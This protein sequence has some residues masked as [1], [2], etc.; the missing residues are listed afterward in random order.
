M[1][2]T[3]LNLSALRPR[4]LSKA[5]QAITPS[6]LFSKEPLFV[7]NRREMLG[8]MGFLG[9]IPMVNSVGTT[10]L[11]SVT[12][13]T[14]K[15]RIVFRMRGKEKWII[16]T[17]LFGGKPRLSLDRSAE[18]LCI[19]LKNATYPGTGVSAD[20]TCTLSPTIKGWRMLLQMPNGFENEGGFESWLLRMRRVLSTAALN[21]T[22][23]TP[24]GD[25]LVQLKGKAAAT[26]WPDWT[27]SL[28]RPR[29]ATIN[30]PEGTLLA[31]DLT[32]SLQR[33]DSG[34]DKTP[35]LMNQAVTRRAAIDIDRGTNKWALSPALTDETDWDFQADDNLFDH[36]R[37]E[38]AESQRGRFYQALLLNGVDAEGILQV[39]P[40]PRLSELGGEVFSLPLRKAAYAVAMNKE[41]RHAALRAS[42]SDNPTWLHLDQHSLLIG[43]D[44]SVQGRNLAF[45]MT[46]L[47]GRL[48]KVS[49]SPA[50]LSTIVPPRNPDIIVHPIHTE[51]GTQLAFTTQKRLKKPA[52]TE[53]VLHVRQGDAVVRPKL[54]LADL[55]VQMIRPEDFLTL[56]FEFYNVQLQDNGDELGIAAPGGGPTITGPKLI[57]GGNAY[58]VVHFPP[59]NIAEEVF[60][61][62]A[63]AAA[64]DPP[65]V[66]AMFSG[67]SRIAYKIPANTAIPYTL[68]GLLQACSD[69]SMNLAPNAR[70]P[71]INRLVDFLG[72]LGYAIE[73]DNQVSN[74]QPLQTVLASVPA[75]RGAVKQLRSRNETLLNQELDTQFGRAEISGEQLANA[76]E[77]AFDRARRLISGRRD[78]LISQTSTLARSVVRHAGTLD[79]SSVALR[80]G[81]IGL[82]NARSGANNITN[83]G[84]SNSAANNN[85]ANNNAAAS[86][87]AVSTGAIVAINPRPSEPSPI[88]TAIEAPFRMYISPNEYAAW[89]HATLPKA[90]NKTGHT[91][92]WHSRMGIRYRGE[93][94]E[95]D[96][97]MKSVRAIWYE[98]KSDNLQNLN[99]VN[100]N[101]S[102]LNNDRS[103]IVDLSSDFSQGFIPKPVKAKQL[104]LSSLG[105]W[106]HLRGNWPVDKID[107]YSLSEWVH[108]GTL[109]RDHYVKVVKE[110]ILYPTKHEA[111]LVRITER[112]FQ[113]HPNDDDANVAYLMQRRF[114][115]VRNPEKLI[116]VSGSAAEQ[117]QMPFKRAEITTLITP[118]LDGIDPDPDADSNVNE[119]VF[120]PQVGNQD[121]LFNL[122]LE[123]T[124]GV[125]HKVSMPL[126]FIDKTVIDAVADGDISIAFLELQQGFN[127][128]S[129]HTAE[130]RNKRLLNGQSVTYTPSA[131]PGDTS[132]ETF[133][134]EFNTVPVDARPFFEPVI[135]RANVVVPAVKHLLGNNMPN[136][137]VNVEYANIYLNHGL[138]NADNKGDVF[139]NFIDTL[140]VNFDGKGEQ[141]G[142]L[143]KPNMEVTAFSRKTGPVGGDANAFATE[144]FNPQEFFGGEKVPMP[145]LFGVIKL[146]DII[147]AAGL[148]ELDKIPKVITES[149]D[150][151]EFF[152]KDAAYFIDVIQNDLKNDVAAS[153]ATQVNNFVGDINGIMDAIEQGNVGAIPDLGTVVSHID[154]LLAGLPASGLNPGIIK[155]A[156]K[157]LHQF[158]SLLG[159]ATGFLDLING[160]LN[161]IEM[162]K[163][164][165]VRLEWRPHLKDWENIF[166]TNEQDTPASMVL[167]VEIRAKSPDGNGGE[168]STDI[169]CSLDNFTINLNIIKAHFE[170]VQFF[171]ST[172][173]KMGIDVVF[174]GIEFDGILKWVEK[175]RD[176][177]P[178]DGFSD[179]PFVDIDASGITA[180]FTLPIPTVAMG[181]FTI[182]NLSLGAQ[183]NLPF[184]GDPATIQFNFNTRENPCT[185][186]VMAIGGSF[187]FGLS[188][189]MEGIRTVEAAIEFG[190]SIAFNIAVASGGVSLMAGIYFK[191]DGTTGD[192]TLTGYLRISGHVS[193]LGLISISLE[194]R[195]ELTYESANGG[196]VKG[197]ASITVE[198]EVLFFSFGVEITVERKFAG[199]N[200]DPTFLEQMG[201]SYIDPVQEDVVEAWPEYCMAFAD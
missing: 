170:R 198:I 11:G 151:V 124:N 185:V 152:L 188:I 3:R 153:F 85:A 121:F 19:Q 133:N 6:E 2:K 96:F 51:P 146:W 31:D 88:H 102:L 186:T 111:A 141:S 106:L 81:T 48:E 40:S 129:E 67:Q 83:N 74:T 47:D 15:D 137:S 49:C 8:M 199:S 167:G 122:K 75:V 104:M 71:E 36:L 118:I 166:L 1:P 70:A 90:S 127:T 109:G 196:K 117:R 79:T 7:L 131:I 17:K 163:E 21:H 119:M 39:K 82:N 22:L 101:R 107:D 179:P 126:A 86:S 65:P 5:K 180:G 165:K 91:E 132:F 115:I 13:V 108:R 182:Q 30:L 50:L 93:I 120:W 123:D 176:I 38:T 58:M 34:N 62:G 35:A 61:E 193:V 140:G 77:P 44:E 97:D 43:N 190:A 37:I 160:F 112:K 158:R 154:S 113:E 149:L 138:D 110:G 25:P 201:S 125:E 66:K 29:L 72:G 23:H 139:F 168:P 52:P 84:A 148:D 73:R 59:Q 80:S 144:N 26:F 135:K 130:A 57:A 178:F 184:I 187:Y 181:V 150:A 100:F 76:N 142:G 177:I 63:N 191:Y 98:N 157:R 41:G 194:L 89:T 116:G 33:K 189:D 169:F 54:F 87:V 32:L 45:E 14:A 10:V 24:A 4:S 55:K 172:G 42:F 195:M 161:A 103:Q 27:L 9:A 143:I 128:N 99:D 78:T 60:P 162:A 53:N 136:G 145:M 94:S 12:M 105:A 95:E 174:G 69:L 114:I 147:G 16:D 18:H 197:R 28:Q 46:A 159:D 183:L 175:L 155:D 20:F 64:P 173:Q 92:L 192:V 171:A 200:G 156:E 164:M 134:V 56:G 68:E